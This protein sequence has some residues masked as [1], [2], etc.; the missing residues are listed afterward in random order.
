MIASLNQTLAVS[1]S[2]RGL[3]WRLET[4]RTGLPFAEVVLLHTLRYRVEQV[5]LI[6]R[7]TGLLLQ[8]VMTESARG[9]DAEMISGMLT[10]I[11]DFVRDSFGVHEGEGLETVQV[12]DLTVWIE[13]GPYAILA[14]IVQGTA[15]P[16]LK[17]IC[18]DALAHIHGEYW[19][20]L[21]AFEGNAAPFEGT[22]SHLEACLSPKR[23]P[24][25]CE[26]VFPFDR[27]IFI[28]LPVVAHRLRQ[29]A[30]FF[31]RMV[32]PP[33]KFGQRVGGEEI[34]AAAAGSNFPRGRLGA[35]F[36]EFEKFRLARFCVG[37]ADAGKAGWLVLFGESIGPST[38]LPS[39]K[40]I[41]LTARADPQPPTGPQ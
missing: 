23:L 4:L 9:L 29:T 10:A 25:L 26:G 41:S 20:A 35:V 11:Q 6:H 31:K 2:L 17:G 30:D 19:Q 22:R 24:D 37:A 13:S 18:E 15:P 38:D 36:A 39:R 14:Y 34:R 5:F 27:K 8:H 16:E 33:F 21:P 1:V 7:Q 12:G 3:K 28:G 32:G 40:R